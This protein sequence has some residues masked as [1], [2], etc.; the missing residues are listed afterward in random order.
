M[1]KQTAD[2]RVNLSLYVMDAE[3]VRNALGH[4]LATSKAMTDD[5]R[6]A[7]HRLIGILDDRIDSAKERI[8]QARHGVSE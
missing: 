1:S 4:S 2:K 8:M 7:T 5:D 3:I 6:R